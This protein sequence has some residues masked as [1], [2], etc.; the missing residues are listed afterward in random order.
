MIAHPEPKFP[1]RATRQRVCGP[2]Q[3]AAT[4][5]HAQHQR[6][7]RATLMQCQRL[8]RMFVACLIQLH[9][10]AIATQ[11]QHRWQSARYGPPC[12]PCQCGQHDERGNGKCGQ[13]DRK[14]CGD[15]QHQHRNA[16]AARRREHQTQGR[17]D[18][19]S[20]RNG[21]RGRS[22]KGRN[23]CLEHKACTSAIPAKAEVT[24]SCNRVCNKVRNT[25]RPLTS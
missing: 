22:D 1:P 21:M 8:Y 18:G 17:R 7:E 6:A 3:M 12:P 19:A 10:G 2:C 24:L 4:A 9:G 5:L 16:Q 25:R 13:M 15:D 14:R 20:H 11:D 23:L